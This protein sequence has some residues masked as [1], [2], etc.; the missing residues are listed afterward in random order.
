VSIEWFLKLKEID[1]LLKAKQT[2]E[3][4]L[5]DEDNRL[6]K[7]EEKRNQAILEM[8]LLN[9][10]IIQLN[11]HLFKIEQQLKILT[12]QKENLF[13]IGKET[14]HLDPQIEQLELQGLEIIDKTE[15][16]RAKEKELSQ[17]SKGLEKTI[18]EISVDV[19]EIKKTEN[20]A[21]HN[22]HLRISYLEEE[23]PES[24]KETFKK[25]KSKNLAHGPFSRNEQG[26]CYFCRYKL[27]RIQESE[28]DLQLLLKQCPQCSRIFLPYG[29]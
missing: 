19:E 29:C 18:I 28:I 12:Q 24:F 6:T 4:H 1:S 14:Q 9:K 2:H 27:S 10:D 13:S 3:K 5:L 26:H 16:L 23:L 15:S 20:Q 25:M 21:L 11:D 17:F 22:A 8:D 7:L